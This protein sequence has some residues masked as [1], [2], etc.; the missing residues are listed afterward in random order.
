MITRQKKYHYNEHTLVFEEIKLTGKKSA[1]RF[2]LFCILGVFL[3]GTTG[4]I[5]YHYA[6]A[7]E[8]YV[9]VKKITFL[10]SEMNR[11]AKACDSVGSILA[12]YYFSRDNLYRTILEIDTLPVTMRTAGSG[13][14]G[15]VEA[16]LPGKT[17][18][19]NLKRK[20][21]QL[22]GQIDIQMN[23]FDILEET[24]I[25]TEK[26][27]T[28]IPAIQPIAQKDLILI[29]SYFGK[30]IDPFIQDEA[31]HYGLDF[32]APVG[33]K[34]YATGDGIVTLLKYSRTGYGNELVINHS[35][36]YST[37]YAHLEKFF[38]SE[39]DSVKRGQLIGLVGNSGR[40]TGPHLHYE[41]RYEGK[42]VNPAFYYSNDL[43]DNE[44][45]LLTNKTN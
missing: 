23:S 13:G 36:G 22:N 45:H 42:P 29:S 1:R 12:G 35:F 18:T 44:F 31:D 33:T 11:L 9:L 15:Q 21:S 25:K 20:I 30:R 37:R 4:Y 43:T 3:C 26:R 40:S 6:F 41:V 14:S 5:L 39:N 2:I 28:A 17:I 32:T 27:H 7:P 34:I 10:E 16:F 19:L 24:A 8:K 38:V